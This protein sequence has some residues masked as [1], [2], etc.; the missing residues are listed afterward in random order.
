MLRVVIEHAVCIVITLLSPSAV[1]ADRL[2]T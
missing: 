2:M 1:C